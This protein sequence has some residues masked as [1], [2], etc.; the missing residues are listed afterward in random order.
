MKNFSLI[1][2]KRFQALCL[3]AVMLSFMAGVSRAADVV[4]I[5]VEGSFIPALPVGYYV[6]Y[7]NNFSYFTPYAQ[8]NEIPVVTV[9]V[10]SN[11]AKTLNQVG[12][13][14]TTNVE[15]NSISGVAFNGTD[16]YYVEKWKGDSCK[17][18]S[19]VGPAGRACQKLRV[20]P[21]HQFTPMVFNYGSNP[22]KSASYLDCTEKADHIYVTTASSCNT[23]DYNYLCQAP[24]Q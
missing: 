9:T 5:A 20:H 4:Y 14:G 19:G 24:Q 11:N 12:V 21:I 22:V 8:Y 3:V 6:S 7:Y 13:Y 2:N 17:I 15:C 16:I 10:Q 23:G 18:D 1:F